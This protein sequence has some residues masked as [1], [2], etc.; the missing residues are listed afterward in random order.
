MVKWKWKSFNPIWL[1]NPKDYIV[2]GILE[3]RVL[4]WVAFSFPRGSSQL[5]DEPRSPALK[6]RIISWATREAPNVTDLSLWS[7]WYLCFTLKKTSYF[8][9]LFLLVG[10]WFMSTYDKTHCN[11]VKTSYLSEFMQV[12]KTLSPNSFP[13]QF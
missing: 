8:F 13:P 5:R 2:H 11:V 9:H 6:V 7:L 10:G 12:I 4:E 1:Y 3:G